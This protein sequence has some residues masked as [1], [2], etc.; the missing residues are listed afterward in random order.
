MSDPLGDMIARIKNAQMARHKT[1][2]IP[3][4]T[5]KANLAK[6]LVEEKYVAS[7]ET[8]D[9]E[10]GHKTIK[11]TLMYNQKKPVIT[12]FRRLSKPGLRLY[13]PAKSLTIPLNEYGTGVISTSKGLMTIKNAMEKNLGGELLC[14][15]W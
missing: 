2:E 11:I 10:S 9:T 4:S 13:S 6:I 14:E 15:I 1:V 8:V 3:H 12:H 5:L 7:E